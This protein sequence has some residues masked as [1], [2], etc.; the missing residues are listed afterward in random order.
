MR[1]QFPDSQAKP[2][3]EAFPEV[4]R[5]KPPRRGKEPTSPTNKVG[6]LIKA[7]LG[8]VRQVLPVSDLAQGAPAARRAEPGRPV[9]AAVE[10]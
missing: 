1:S 6:L 9:V 5:L 2:D 8:A 4:R 10:Q 3:I 7:A